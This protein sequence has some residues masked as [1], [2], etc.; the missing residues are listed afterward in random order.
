MSAAETQRQRLELRLKRDGDCLV[1]TGYITSRG[2]G[3]VS[4]KLAHRVYYELVRGP[5]PD[6]LTIDHLCRN[7]ACCNPDHLEPVTSLE[8]V[9][10]A[11]KSHCT[12]GHPLSGDNIIERYGYREC[13]ACC[14]RR[15]QERNERRRAER[16]VLGRRALGNNATKTHC[17]R[18][19][20]LSG[21]NLYMRKNGR[22][23]R[24][25]HRAAVREYK[26]LRRATHA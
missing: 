19:H 6:G 2:Y 3:R 11:R 12:H 17:W 8:N 26:A 20:P 14:L 7:K 15:R 25:C 4:S 9:R 21:D 23:C 13:L 18:G 22:V 24:T 10:R 5:I 16:A 1:W